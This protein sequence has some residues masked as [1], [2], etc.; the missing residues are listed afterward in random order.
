[1]SSGRLILPL[2]EP[3]L[4]AQG[5]PSVG[6][7]L[8]VFLTGT[9]TFAELFADVDLTTPITNPQVSDSA[10]RF[11]TQATVIWADA[12]QAYDCVLALPDGENFQYENLFLLGA[13]EAI[14]GFAPINSPNFTGIPTAPTPAANDASSKI[15]TTQFVAAAIASA[16]ITPPGQYGL[17]AMASLP[18]GWLACD[19]SAVSRTTYAALFGAI[20]TTYGAGDGVTTF[21]LPPFSINGAFG[22]ANGGPSAAL[23][24]LQAQQLQGHLH[25]WGVETV[26]GTGGVV[27]NFASGGDNTV[28][29]NQV[30]TAGHASG[31]TT[32]PEAAGDGTNGAVAVGTETRPVNL[33]WVVAIH[34]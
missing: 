13:P 23:G 21:N 9:D 3:T 26:S 2:S 4:T 24:V 6:A 16:S 11:Y 8:T 32:T 7:S 10:G 15:A 30:N 20:S 17:F 5:V 29:Q 19:G 14:S 33:A 27:T 25:G 18:A 12:T 22:R 34:L 28:Y 1:M 31:N